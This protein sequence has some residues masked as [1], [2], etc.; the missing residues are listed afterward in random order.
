MRS[1]KPVTWFV[2]LLTLLA[3]TSVSAADV[4]DGNAYASLEVLQSGVSIGDTVP[5]KL[6][7]ARLE[8]VS[9]IVDVGRGPTEVPN[10]GTLCL[11]LGPRMHILHDG[12]RNGLPRIGSDGSFEFTLDIPA[13]AR[14][15]GRTVYV[16]ALIRDRQAPAGY[17]ISNVAEIGIDTVLVEDFST[18]TY[19]DSSETTAAWSGDGS[20]SGVLGPVTT[21]EEA[22]TPSTPRAIPLFGTSEP[23]TSNG[24]R[25]QMYF[26]LPYTRGWKL[27][28]LSWPPASGTAV[29]ASYPDLRVRV[30]VAPMWPSVCFDSN[31]LEPISDVSG[32]YDVVSVPGQT[33]VPWPAFNNELPTGTRCVLDIRLPQGGTATNPVSGWVLDGMLWNGADVRCLGASEF[34]RPAF[35]YHLAETRSVALSLFYDTGIEQPI[36]GRPSIDASTPQATSVEVIYQGGR[37]TDGDGTIDE[38]SPWSADAQGADGYRYLRYRIELDGHFTWGLV[39]VVGSIEIPVRRN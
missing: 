17:A 13:Q 24:I 36:Y 29:T 9:V 5:L 39:P 2:V 21:V 35:R 22:F 11:D 4:C 15:R 19:R 20:C 12:I 32:T 31:L 16:Q 14:L 30:A 33:W 6:T 34:L 8:R 1:V 10:V 25:C 26:D 7:G 37:D 3:A 38:V 23:P 28:G 18:T 27:V